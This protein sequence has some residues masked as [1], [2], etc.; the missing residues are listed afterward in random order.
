[1]AD[2]V[3][4]ILN[5]SVSKLNGMLDSIEVA[6]NGVELAQLEEI[7]NDLKDVLTILKKHTE[8]LY[9]ES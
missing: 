3:F 8:V 9:D 5:R 6:L 1:M 4:S 7:E 2:S